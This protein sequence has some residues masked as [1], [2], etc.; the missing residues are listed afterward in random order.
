MCITCPTS[1]AQWLLQVRIIL[2]LSL[3]RSFSLYMY[4]CV[5]TWHNSAPRIFAAA[6]RNDSLSLC[7]Y[8]YAFINLATKSYTTFIST[9][10]VPCALWSAASLPP[11]HPAGVT[12]KFHWRAPQS[13]IRWRCH[14]RAA[15]QVHKQHI[16]MYEYSHVW[17]HILY[18]HVCLVTISLICNKRYFPE[19]NNPRYVSPVFAWSVC[20]VFFWNRVRMCSLRGYARVISNPTAESLAEFVRVGERRTWPSIALIRS[21]C[22]LEIVLDQCVRKLA[23]EAQETAMK[24]R[25]ARSTIAGPSLIKSTK[26]RHTHLD[27]NN[28]FGTSIVLHGEK[29]HGTGFDET[30]VESILSQV[31]LV[32]LCCVCVCPRWFVCTWNVYSSCGLWRKTWC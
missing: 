12:A 7:M 3:Y 1:I 4:V 31:R 21:Q 15:T 19:Q 28:F 32:F 2:S 23:S 14:N 27:L 13:K 29:G 11:R 5:C 24:N 9:H 8:T 10:R 25:V 30:I 20:P 17:M 26:R 18:M 22:E 6:G 16:H